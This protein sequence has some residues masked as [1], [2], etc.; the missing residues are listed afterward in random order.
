MLQSP[1]NSGSVARWPHQQQTGQ[2]ILKETYHDYIVNASKNQ[3]L[4]RQK[5]FSLFKE[6]LTSS[7]YSF[8]SLDFQSDPDSW[9]FIT[10]DLVIQFYHWLNLNDRKFERRMKAIYTLRDHARF[11]Y[12]LNIIE[13][14]VYLAL[15][16]LAKLLAAKNKQL[17]RKPANKS[18]TLISEKQ[19]IK[20]L[21]QSHQFPDHFPDWTARDRLIACLIIEHGLTRRDIANLTW[22]DVSLKENVLRFRRIGRAGTKHEYGCHPLGRYTQRAFL[23]YQAYFYPGQF[24]RHYY[25]LLVYDSSRYKALHREK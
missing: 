4:T 23:E 5:S 13:A 18:A 24:P 2:N 21:T 8:A 25:E 9:Q 6:F 11:A 10:P 22:E 3:K 1:T 12:E 20:I 17:K 14:P 7:A 15:V 16:R 19:I